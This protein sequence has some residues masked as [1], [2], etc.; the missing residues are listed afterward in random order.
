MCPRPVVRTG[1]R[2]PSPGWNRAGWLA[3]GIRISAG[4]LFALQRAHGTAAALSS[5][6]CKGVE[7]ELVGVLRAETPKR[8][9]QKLFGVPGRERRYS[10]IMS[11]LSKLYSSCH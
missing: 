4:E 9:K 2:V 7:E 6:P 8:V 5:L 3:R 10:F 11:A 1:V